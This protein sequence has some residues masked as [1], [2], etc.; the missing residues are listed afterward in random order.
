MFTHYASARLRPSVW[1]NIHLSMDR[2]FSNLRWTYYKSLHVAWAMFFSWLLTACM[3]ANTCERAR[4][5]GKIIH[6]SLDGFSSN[7]MGTYYRWPQVTWSTHLSSRT[8]VTRA[9]SHVINCSLIY[10]RFLF[11]FGMNILHLTTSSKGYILF[12]FTHRTA[13]MRASAR[14]RAC[15]WFNSQSSL[16]GFSSN[17]MGTYYK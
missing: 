5:F 16:E 6:S 3:H 4:A 12:M 9:W 11:K 8:A 1:W 14:V 10:G 2:R 13:R 15:V 7:M 17:V